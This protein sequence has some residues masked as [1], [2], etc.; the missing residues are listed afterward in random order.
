MG[1]TKKYEMRDNMKNGLHP[2]DMHLPSH[3]LERFFFTISK[4]MHCTVGDHVVNI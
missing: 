1:H 2:T 4:K 3:V